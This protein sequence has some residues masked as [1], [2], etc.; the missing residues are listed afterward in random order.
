MV[1]QVLGCTLLWGFFLSDLCPIPTVA[2]LG[3]G[4]WHAMQVL[5]LLGE[6]GQ[7][8]ERQL[9]HEARPAAPPRDLWEAGRKQFPA[10]SQVGLGCVCVGRVSMM[11]PSVDQ[12]N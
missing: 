11:W 1:S 9:G 3:F 8:W 12:P 7:P 2:A 6:S 4:L 5:R 10:A